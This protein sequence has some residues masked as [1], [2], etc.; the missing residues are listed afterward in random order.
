MNLETILEF[1]YPDV[2]GICNN[3][4]KNCL[5]KK[6]ELKIRKY[7]INKIVDLNRNVQIKNS[8][9]KNMYF[10]Y[11]ISIYKYE[12]I[13]RQK[14]IEYKFGDKPYL[15]KMFSKI[16]LK[17]KKICGFFKKYDI[18]IPVP[19]HKEKKHIR[20]YNQTELIA[21][22]ISKNNHNLRL[23]KNVLIRKLSTKPQSS[24]TK[25]ERKENI[26]NAFDIINEKRIENKNIILF[27]DIYTTGSTVN[28]C[29]KILKQKGVKK[30]MI[31]TIA[32]D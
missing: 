8:N 22:E 16:I 5:C 12:D 31:L 15:Y 13:I 29:S 32:K 19:I 7:E 20:G 28:E 9:Y 21:K 17:N 24:L 1:L 23:E 25:K 3:I 30:I 2:C 4:C 26:Q 14:I 6:C 11:I 18:I 10:D 27:D